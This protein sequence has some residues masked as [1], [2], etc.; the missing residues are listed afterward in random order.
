MGLGAFVIVFFNLLKPYI[1]ETLTTNITLFAVNTGGIL[2]SVFLFYHFVITKAF[3]SFFNEEKW[4]VGKHLLTFFCLLIIAS[5]LNWMFNQYIVINENSPIKNYTDF[6]KNFLGIAVFPIIFYLFIDER[7]KRRKR[8]KVSKEL[9]QQKKVVVET[10]SKED[11]NITIL[12]TNKKEDISFN[13]NDLLYINSDGNYVNFFLK[14]SK[15]IKK[16]ILRKPLFAI[17][18]EMN[19]FKTIMRCHKSYI[20]NTQYVDSIS[21][22]ARGYY[23]HFNELDLEIPV[24]RKF[25]KKDLLKVLNP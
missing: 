9:M 7:I 2:S 12:S 10:V 3:P 24:S 1:L 20:I 23:L 17:E 25:S 14:N 18:K 11:K 4:T 6:L 13:I 8:E 16:Q 19:T 15:E 22:N 21:G 5:F